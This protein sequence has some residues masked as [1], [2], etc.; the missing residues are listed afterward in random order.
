MMF[1]FLHLI[2]NSFFVPQFL[3]LGETVLTLQLT[4][5]LLYEKDQFP[6]ASGIFQNTVTNGAVPGTV[7]PVL[8]AAEITPVDNTEA[9]I[10]EQAVSVY[11]TRFVHPCD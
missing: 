3:E 7:G 4:E 1:S 5:L 9:P 8:G 6:G 10:S 2:A 11:C